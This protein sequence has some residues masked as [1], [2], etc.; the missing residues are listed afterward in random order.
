M[1][2]DNL[3]QRK[4]EAFI[5]G[6][7][8]GLR[9]RGYDELV[10]ESDLCVA[11]IQYAAAYGKAPW[12]VEDGTRPGQARSLIDEA[13]KLLI[14]RER[15]AILSAAD[16]VDSMDTT[17]E[18]EEDWALEEIYREE[19]ARELIEAGLEEIV[20]DPMFFMVIVR[21]L[22]RP[23]GSL[24]L[25]KLSTSQERLF[26]DCDQAIADCDARARY[27]A[28]ERLDALGGDK[29]EEPEMKERQTGLW[30]K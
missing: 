20:D 8:Q 19:L 4:R 3:D 11:A 18:S 12:T 26:R 27:A 7:K 21:Y 5:S 1:G 28:R 13:A 30:E 6:L 15:Q 24:G 9:E 2:M 25:E 10:S 22:E 17:E 14:V 23:S 16:E 29:S